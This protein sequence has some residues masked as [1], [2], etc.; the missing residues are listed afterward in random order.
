[1]KKRNIIWSDEAK[2]DY[3]ENIEFLLHKWTEQSAI[4]FIEE[5]ELVLDLI[6]NN[7]RLYPLTEY[8]S[9]RRAVIRRQITLF[10]EEKGSAVYLVR[11]WNTFKDPDSL[12]I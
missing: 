11:F 5:V 4:N 2:F 1:M 10:Y 3:E 7:P 6:K 8:K 9:I 12:D